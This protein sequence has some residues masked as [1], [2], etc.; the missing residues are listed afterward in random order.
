V[1]KFVALMY[2]ASLGTGFGALAMYLGH[3]T[4]VVAGVFTCIGTI[5]GYIV[6]K[7]T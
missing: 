2:L 6:G 7:K 5:A 4:V 3:N 1:N